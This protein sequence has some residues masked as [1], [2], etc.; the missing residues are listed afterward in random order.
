MAKRKDGSQIGSRPLKVK[1]R[2]ISLREGGMQHTV[3]KF[4]T[5]AITLLKTSFQSEGLHA[6]LWAPKVTE[7]LVMGILRLPLRS[8]GTK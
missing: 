3:G 2:P 1:N 5:R 6:K 4:S 7:I 8:P